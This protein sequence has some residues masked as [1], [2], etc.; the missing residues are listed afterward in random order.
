MYVM[1]VWYEFVFG[2]LPPF[3]LNEIGHRQYDLYLL[4]KPDLPWTYDNMR[5]YPDEKTRVLLFEKY[6]ALMQSQHTP[7]YVIDGIGNKR[8]EHAIERIYSLL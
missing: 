4:C 2:R 7:F 8:T 1:R 3:I 5:E 6:H